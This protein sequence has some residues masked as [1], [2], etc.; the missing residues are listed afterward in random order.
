MHLQRGASAVSSRKGSQILCNFL[1][2]NANRL[3]AYREERAPWQ[4]EK[5]AR[6]RATFW[7]KMQISYAPT[8]RS[9]RDKQ[10]RK[11]DSL[12]HLE[13]K[14][15]LV[16]CL[17]RGGSTATIRNGN[18]I[19]CNFLNKNANRLSA[20]K[21][22]RALQQTEKETRFCG[23]FWTKMQIGWAPT[24]RSER[25]NKRKRKLDFVQVSEQKCK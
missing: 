12:G 23:A 20:Y 11:L 13:Q 9:K 14:C 21:E 3:W 16:E 5:E 10:R 1:N 17:Q 15:K 4:A 22:E 8:K 18:Q 19:L 7:T 25:C 24:K 6:F 2:K